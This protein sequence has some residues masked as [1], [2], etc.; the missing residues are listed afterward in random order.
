M[1]IKDIIVTETEQL[2]EIA[3]FLRAAEFIWNLIPR[4]V[5]KKMPWGKNPD[6]WDPEEFMQY[7]EKTGN[8]KNDL[9]N[10]IKAVP[11]VDQL[12]KLERQLNNYVKTNT[13]AAPEGRYLID[14]IRVRKEELMDANQGFVRPDDP[15][16]WTYM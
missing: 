5:K 9:E 6:T 4:S 8:P 11:T 15:T 1:R 13:N 2:N 7:L 14:I 10:L 16:D 12:N 3:S